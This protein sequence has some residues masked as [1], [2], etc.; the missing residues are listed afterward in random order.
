MKKLIFIS[1]LTMTAIFLVVGC[2]KKEKPTELPAET[3]AEMPA[4]EEAKGGKMFQLTSPAFKDRERI[5]A[6]YATEGV[7]G[8]KNLS[9]PLKWENAPEGTKS[10]AIVI[11]DKHPVANNWVHWLVI[12]IPTNVNSLPEG[13]S[14]KNM[15]T[16]SK[17]L[18]NSYGSQGYGG[19]QPPP[20]TGD[21]DY[22]ITVYALNVEKLDLDVDTS[23]SEFMQAVSDKEL[24]STQLTGLFSQ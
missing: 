10:F 12:N 23:L 18:N 2:A 5:P 7:T 15:P 16:G 4:K 1:L 20:G 6:K 17:E 19:P 14:R 13:A 9:V 24:A 3:P 11:V 8:G 21:H 22:V